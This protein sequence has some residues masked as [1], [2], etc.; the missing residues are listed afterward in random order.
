MTAGAFTKDALTEVKNQR[1]FDITVRQR[2][3]TTPAET[4]VASIRDQ[5]LYSIIDEDAAVIPQPKTTAKR[6]PGLSRVSQNT[7]ASHA[8]A[9]SGTHTTTGKPYLNGRP[10]VMVNDRAFY[11][12]HIKGATFDVQGIGVAGMFGYV[13]G[14][15]QHL[16]LIHI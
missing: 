11:Q 8:W 2:C 13:I 10:M 15:T 9:I 1:A 14:S 16:S 3:G 5:W 4:C 6:S 7:K 12:S